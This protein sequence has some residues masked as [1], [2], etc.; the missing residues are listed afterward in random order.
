V[1]LP[2]EYCDGTLVPAGLVIALEQSAR[3]MRRAGV[4]G[5]ADA[6]FGQTVSRFA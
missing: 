1:Q 5:C 4:R 6:A 3:D 2:R